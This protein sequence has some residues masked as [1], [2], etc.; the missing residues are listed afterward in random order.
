MGVL[1]IS[2]LPEIKDFS[3]QLN[4]ATNVNKSKIACLLK[5]KTSEVHGRKKTG[6]KKISAKILYFVI[7]SQIF[8]ARDG[9]LF[10]LFIF[11][12]FK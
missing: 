3:I 6:T 11:I 10:I 4:S 12:K 9:S 8:R 2:I 7:L 1:F 5:S